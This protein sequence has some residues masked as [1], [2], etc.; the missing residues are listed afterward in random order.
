[1]ASS[2]TTASGRYAEEAATLW[3]GDH[4]APTIR[5]CRLLRNVPTWP[6]T[7]FTYLLHAAFTYLGCWADTPTPVGDNSNNNRAVPVRLGTDPAMTVEACGKLARDA[8][9][10]LF[11]L[12]WSNR[13][14]KISPNCPCC[15]PFWINLP[16][17]L[18]SCFCCS[19]SAGAR[20]T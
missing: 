3:G 7:S 12:Q 8:G 10:S 4:T 1:M 16:H 20:A 17:S 9:F 13:E 5:G 2:A 15:P 11:A 6:C 18:L 14:S 19:Q